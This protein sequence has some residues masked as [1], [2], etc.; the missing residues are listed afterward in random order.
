[1]KIFKALII[2]LMLTVAC[3]HPVQAAFSVDAK[4]AIAIDAKTGQI[5]YEQNADKAEGIASMT[6]LIT[7][8]LTLQAIK[9]GKLSWNQKVTPSKNIVKVANTAGFSNVPLK[10]GHQYTIKQLYQATLI[11][12][13][14][15]AAMTLAQAVSKTQA[16]FVKKMKLQLKKWKITD[17]KIYTT[18]GLANGDVYEDKVKSAS[19]KAE[20]ELSA[21]DMA[22]VGWHVYHDFPFIVKTT[23]ISKLDFVDGTDTTKMTT[24]NWMLKGQSQASSKYET[25]G[26]KTGTSDLAKACFIGLSKVQDQEVITVVMGASHQ[27]G[28]DPARFVQT[29]KLLAYLDENWHAETLNTKLKFKYADPV[30]VKVHGQDIVWGQDSLSLKNTAGKKNSFSKGKVVG[31]SVVKNVKTIFDKPLKVNLISDQSAHEVNIFVKAWRFFFGA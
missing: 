31:Y 14:N 21:K 4:S 6:K 2:S 13:A 3:V 9:D 30:N 23:S 16:N 12:S 29:K 20:N 11:E 19:D 24:F 5:L 25:I 27:D 26:L 7:V 17:Y 8:Y 22:K 15:G 10:E 18:C 28:N 1:M